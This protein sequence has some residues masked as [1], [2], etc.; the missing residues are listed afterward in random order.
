MLGIFGTIENPTTY[1]SNNGSGLFTLLSNILKLAGVIA[2]LFFIV[3]IILAGYGYIS[4]NGD[5][6]KT[7]AAWAKIYQSIIGLLIVASAFVLASVIGKLV[8]IDNILTPTIY[9]PN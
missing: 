7:E 4:A 8:G 3:Q 6:K 1:T 5:P 2:G 9:G